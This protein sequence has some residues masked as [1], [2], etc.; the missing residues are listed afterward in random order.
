MSIGDAPSAAATFLSR[1]DSSARSFF[2]WWLRELRAMVPPRLRRLGRASVDFLLVDVGERAVILRRARAQGEEEIGRIA[3]TDADPAS[4]R[5]QFNLFRDKF[6]GGVRQVILRLPP[7]Q[8]L[9]KM[10]DLPAAARE[11]LREV[12]GFEMD[13]TTPFAADD[14]YFTYTIRE[15]DRQTRRMV[16]ELAILP[17][18]SADAAIE[19]AEGWGLR[20]DRIE[21]QTLGPRAAAP[22]EARVDFLP[23]ASGARSSQP[24]RWLSAILAATALSLVVAALYLPLEKQR[25]LIAAMS[26]DITAVKAKADAGRKVQQELEQSVQ[27]SNFIIDKKLQRPSFLDALDE[28]TRLLPND[29]WVIRVRYFNGELQVFGNSPSAS[30][31]IGVLED[32][33]IFA[34]AQFRAPVTRDPRLGLERFHIGL[35]VV[36]PERPE[37]LESP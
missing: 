29:A 31:L 2:A 14:V 30:A 13:R 32:S 20:V 6:D 11:N 22:V 18:A 27:Q 23:I 16:V 37:L 15:V 5:A 35:Q 21:A 24:T 26:Q 33:P 10:L 36:G 4:R 34:G 9:R 17:R 3:L 12:L 19:M 1:F 28:L 25:R 7:G 8:F